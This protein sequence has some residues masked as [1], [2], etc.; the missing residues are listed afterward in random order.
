MSWSASCARLS[1][2]S[3]SINVDEDLLR[4]RLL[5]Q[6]AVNALERHAPPHGAVARRRL[7]QAGEQRLLADSPRCADVLV[8]ERCGTSSLRCGKTALASTIRSTGAAVPSRSPR[9]SPGSLAIPFLVDISTSVGNAIRRNGP[10]IPVQIEPKDLEV[11]RREALISSATVIAMDMSRSMFSNG[12]FYEAKRVAFALNTL[13][14]TRFPARR[15]ALGRLLLFRHGATARTLCCNQTG[16]TG[17][18]RTS[19]SRWQNP[20]SS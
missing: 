11:H 3:T 1:V 15:P 13:I 6:D 19:S 12:A 18:A 9:P 14:K 17:A 2:S 7:R 5:D 8:S 20:A 4:R 16:L 10:G